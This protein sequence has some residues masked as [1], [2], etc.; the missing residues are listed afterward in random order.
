MREYM[1]GFDYIDS[2][3][4]DLQ[5][6]HSS[7]VEQREKIYLRED[8]ITVMQQAVNLPDVGSTPTLPELVDCRDK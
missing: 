1:D 7:V 2:L 3:I 5:S 8:S 6:R 4:Q